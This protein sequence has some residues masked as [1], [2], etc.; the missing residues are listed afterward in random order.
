MSNAPT[1]VRLADTFVHDD[2]LYA[3]TTL[4]TLVVRPED[5]SIDGIVDVRLGATPVA[6]VDDRASDQGQSLSGRSPR[7]RR[8]TGRNQRCEGQKEAERA[9]EAHWSPGWYQAASAH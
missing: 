1:G 3:D 9:G 2:A 4:A 5:D 8:E 7:Q 6:G